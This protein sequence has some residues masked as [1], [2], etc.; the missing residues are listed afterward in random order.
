MIRSLGLSWNG[1]YIPLP[2]GRYI[3]E[4]HLDSMSTEWTGGDWTEVVRNVRTFFHVLKRRGIGRGSYYTCKRKSTVGHNLI[5]MQQGSP[6][7]DNITISFPSIFDTRQKMTL[8]KPALSSPFT[9]L[10]TLGIR[11]I[12]FPEYTSVSVKIGFGCSD[13]KLPV[14]SKRWS[15]NFKYQM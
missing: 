2:N 1:E 6:S 13:P 14:I 11:S 5:I 15:L 8:S 3:W 10:R 9:T 4:T 12:N 7:R